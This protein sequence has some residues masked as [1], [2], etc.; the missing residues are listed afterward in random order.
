MYF[1]R[2]RKKKKYHSQKKEH[3]PNALKTE[4]K[5]SNPLLKTH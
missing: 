5:I 3:N 1:E 2:E 4:K